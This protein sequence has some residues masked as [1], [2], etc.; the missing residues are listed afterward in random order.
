MWG[1][2]SGRGGGKGKGLLQDSLCPPGF[3]LAELHNRHG[4]GE[5]REG[6]EGG[7]TWHALA[8]T[9][10]SGEEVLL[11]HHISVVWLL[12]DKGLIVYTVAL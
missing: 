9:W 11:L 5:I 4:G 10:R 3:S 6:E 2:E 8:N 1:D 7:P 12:L